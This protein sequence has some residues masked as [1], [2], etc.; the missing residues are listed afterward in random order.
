MLRLSAGKQ[1]VNLAGQA[2]TERAFEKHQR[3]AGRADHQVDRADHAV[4]HDQVEHDDGQ[5]PGDRPGKPLLRCAGPLG[6]LI[7]NREAPEDH[8]RRKSRV[9]ENTD[10]KI[11]QEGDHENPGQTKITHE[12]GIHE[13][14]EREEKQDPGRRPYLT[15]V[16]HRHF[17]ASHRV[18]KAENPAHCHPDKI[19]IAA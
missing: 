8:A 1:V 14:N 9:D 16:E 2:D 13:R 19:V 4:E 11:D 17:V 12:P 15:F 10:R 3:Q 6:C 18:T 5:Y 7:A